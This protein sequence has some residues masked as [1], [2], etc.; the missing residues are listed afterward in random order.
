MLFLFSISFLIN[1]NSLGQPTQWSCLQG[2]GGVNDDKATFVASEFNG[3]GDVYV[4]GTFKSPT[5]VFGSTTLTNTSPGTS[6]I[7]LVKYFGCSIIWAKSYGTIN[8]DVGTGV[9]VFQSSVYITGYF[10][11]TT[12]SIGAITLTN[13]GNDDGFA[14]K[15]DPNGNVIWAKSFGGTGN[16]RP[17]ACVNDQLGLGTLNIIGSFDSPFT[18]GTNTLT[19]AGN[20]DIF[21]LRYN[22][23]GSVTLAR[24]YGSVDNDEA[25]SITDDGVTKYIC[26]AFKGS[27]IAFGSNTLT[28]INAGTFDAF[29]VK[30]DGS[31]TETFASGFGGVGDDRATCLPKTSF[32]GICAGIYN[33]PSLIA[34]SVTITNNGVG[35]T[36]GFIISFSPS[37]TPNWAKTVGG[38]DDDAIYGIATWYNMT[39]VYL[40]GSFNSASL[41]LNNYTLNNVN[42]GTSD[43]L[44]AAFDCSGNALLAKSA[45]SM[46]NDV[47]FS[48]NTNKGLSG[49]YE[50]NVAGSYGAPMFTLTNNSFTATNNGGSDMFLTSLDD[51]PNSIEEVKVGEEFLIY[52][53]PV[54]NK[55]NI[56]FSK[57]SNSKIKLILTNVIGQM[58]YLNENIQTHQ[59]IDLSSYPS[60]IYFLK[61]QSEAE[62]KVFKIIKE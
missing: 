46:G 10:N 18:I 45:G 23:T 2:S 24:G 17:T 61:T 35:T 56:E 7:F 26:G 44:L 39:R 31:F 5:I 38:T 52:P 28:N 32:C 59:E 41:A 11:S 60:G 36:D 13:S 34:G 51:S 48:V 9:A 20:S 62:Q 55:M 21:W 50:L 47:G 4:I 42:A 25:N 49:P 54:T 22:S 16:D 57:I 58:I 1:K 3:L 14:A 53:N 8:N 33:S 30:I 29:L 6:D 43:L 12:M 27:S 37:L 19:S 40:T 15:V